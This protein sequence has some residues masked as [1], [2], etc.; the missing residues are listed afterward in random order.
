MERVS[1][2][3]GD[4]PVH[5]LPLFLC[6][7]L[8]LAIIHE[9]KDYIR[10]MIDLSRNTD[11]INRQNYQRQV[12]EKVFLYKTK[13]L[14]FIFSYIIMFVSHLTL[15]SSHPRLLSTWR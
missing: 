14:F 1:V 5:Q 3:G 11:F 8:H 2:L 15:S 10:T 13:I 4:L 6:R 7:L 12:G 9:A